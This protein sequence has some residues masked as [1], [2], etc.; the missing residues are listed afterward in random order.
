MKKRI[1]GFVYLILALFS[2]LYISKYDYLLEAVSKIYLTGHVTAYLE[3]YKKFDNRVLPAS[4]SPQPW[5][6]HSSYNKISISSA[7]ETYHQENETVAFL[8]IKEDSLIYENYYENFGPKTKSNSFSVVKSM[9]SAMMGKAIEQGYIESLDQ[10]VIDFLPELKGPFANQVTVGD[11]SSMASGLKWSEKY[12]SP[13]SV[14]TAAYFV[15]DLGQVMLDQPINKEP[16]KSFRY[17]SGTTQLLGMVIT[18]ATGKNLTAYFYESLWNSMGAE[19]EALW[20]L[21]SNEKGL[22]KAYCCLASNARDFARFGKLYKNYGKWNGNTILDSTFIAKSLKPRFAESPQYGYGWWLENYNEQRVFMMRG[23]L[24]QYIIVLPKDD[25]IIVRLGH[26]KGKKI[27]GNPYTEDIYV[28]M[29]A[30]LDI[31]S[32]VP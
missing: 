12:Y 18:K 30:A 5:P 19:G 25:L 17:T 4:T 22:E 16:G 21:D 32:D 20:Q 9:I 6:L 29:Q 27:N 8:V 15:K 2:L 1:K 31:T 3:D 24:G 26:K 14:T 10:K 23:H 13:F 28:Y 7:L 11:L